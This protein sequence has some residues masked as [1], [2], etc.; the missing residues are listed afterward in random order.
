[1]IAICR[2]FHFNELTDANDAMKAELIST[3]VKTSSKF[4]SDTTTDIITIVGL[5]AVS[6]FNIRDKVDF[7]LVL[8]AVIRLERFECDI[9]VSMNVPVITDVPTA[10][11]E[12]KWLD[13]THL[14]AGK[15]YSETLIAEFLTIFEESIDSMV[16]HDTSLFT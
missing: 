10:E 15:N 12:Q 13:M 6:K 3:D 16:L 4:L 5:Q 1:M 2:D 8:M 9:I 14:L 11:L 7:I